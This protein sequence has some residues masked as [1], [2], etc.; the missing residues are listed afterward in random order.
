MEIRYE[1]EKKIQTFLVGKLNVDEVWENGL[2]TKMK[3]KIVERKRMEEEEE[4]ERRHK[5]RV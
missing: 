3:K 2:F 1:E 5:K 4:E